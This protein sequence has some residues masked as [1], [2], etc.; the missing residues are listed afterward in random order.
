MDLEVIFYS[1]M[2]GKREPDAMYQEKADAQLVQEDPFA[3]ANLPTQGF[4]RQFDPN[5]RMESLG[6]DRGISRKRRY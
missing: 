1:S 6:T 5:R 3:P 2:R 4:Q